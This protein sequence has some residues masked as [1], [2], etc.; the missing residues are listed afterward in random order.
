M[1]DG[2]CG[3]VK[4]DIEEMV[5]VIFFQVIVAGGNRCRVGKMSVAMV[6]TVATTVLE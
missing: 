4:M 6:G 3:V 5:V 1:E 2:G